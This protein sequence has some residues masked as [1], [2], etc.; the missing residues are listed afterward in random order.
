LVKGNPLLHESLLGHTVAIAN[1]GVQLLVAID[2]ISAQCDEDIPCVFYPMLQ[3]AQGFSDLCCTVF[4]RI[5]NVLCAGKPAAELTL[6]LEDVGFNA[7]LYGLHYHTLNA[8][9]IVEHAKRI[10][11]CLHAIIRE[12]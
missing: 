11:R 1:H 12:A 3:S 7:R 6:M 2:H 9:R 8:K 5:G 10:Y 4:C